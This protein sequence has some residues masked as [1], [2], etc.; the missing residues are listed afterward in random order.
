MKLY[1]TIPEVGGVLGGVEKHD[2]H[3]S[4]ETWL[5]MFKGSRGYGQKE[6]GF[7]NVLVL[8]VDT[9]TGNWEAEGFDNVP[10]QNRVSRFSGS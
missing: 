4:V 5:N 6:P 9:E 2:D 8:I 1:F 3:A 10:E 7:A